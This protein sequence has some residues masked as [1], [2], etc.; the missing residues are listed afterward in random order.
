MSF[1]DALR[2]TFG[3][4]ANFSG[5]SRRAEYCYFTLF[6]LFAYA[7]I[8]L[9]GATPPFIGPSASGAC[10]VSCRTERETLLHRVRKPLLYPT[11]LRGQNLV[12]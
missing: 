4:Y 8:F 2:A 3:N 6:I 1:G 12:L 7:V 10:R 9:L 11:D 5:R